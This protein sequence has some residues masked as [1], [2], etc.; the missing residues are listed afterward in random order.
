M[1]ILFFFFFFILRQLDKSVVSIIFKYNSSK[2]ERKI[3]WLSGA[4]EI[5]GTSGLL[6]NSVCL[7]CFEHFACVYLS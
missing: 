5:N 3:R 1:F 7:I 2:T 4:S 6:W